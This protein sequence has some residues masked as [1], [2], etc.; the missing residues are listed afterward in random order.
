MAKIYISSTYSDLKEYRE[1]VYDILRKMRHDVIAMEDYNSSDERPLEKCLADVDNNCDLYVGIFAWR[2]GYIPTKDNPLNKSITELEYRQ[3]TDSKKQRRIFLLE[4]RAPW[5]PLLMDAVTGDSEQGKR[6]KEFR[7]ELGREHIAGFFKAPDE[8]ASLVAAAVNEWEKSQPTPTPVKPLVTAKFAPPP[9]PVNFIA[10]PEELDRLR[11]AVLSGNGSRQVALTAVVGMGGTGKSVLATALCHD[12]EVHAAFPDGVIWVT[13]GR[14]PGN[15]VS[16]LAAVEVALGDAPEHYTTPEVSRDRFRALVAS[17]TALL[18]LDDVWHSWCVEA[19]RAEA[20]HCR[21]IFTTRDRNIALSLSAQEIRLGV[22][23][24]DQAH[25]LLQEWAGRDDPLHPAIAERLGCLPVALKLAGA[26]L[27]EGMSGQEWLDTF[28]HVSQM[29][30]SRRATNKDENLQ[31]CFALSLEQL[32]PGDQQLYHTF[33]VFPEDLP[34]PQATVTRLSKQLQ[35]QLSDFDCQELLQ[36]FDRLALLEYNRTT[37]TLLLHDLLY[38][39]AREQLNDHVATTH[40]ALLTAYNSSGKAWAQIPNDGYLYTHLAYHLHAAQRTD[41]LQPLLFD[42]DWLHA[43]LAAT[44]VNAVLSDYDYVA[45]NGDAQLLQ[46]AIRLSAHVVATDHH[47]LRSQLQGRLRAHPAPALQ[48][49]CHRSSTIQQEVTIECL[50]ATLTAPGGPLLRTLSGHSGSV[51]AVGVLPD[52]QHLVSA[53]N[54][55]TLKVWDWRTGRILATFT[56]DHPLTTCVV[57]SDGKTVIVG[58]TGGGCIFY[59]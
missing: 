22:L 17:K 34:V 42:C 33:G 48:Q 46:D 1:A 15:L 19:F 47:Q 53:S 20:P 11:S 4:P 39:Y 57:T 51:R 5:S 36:E 3:A 14:E 29:R 25:A 27:R 56:A 30:L 37:R 40:T 50:S 31:T 43:K 2:Y 21:T 35:P 38:D 9:L 8:L 59:T 16:Q 44:D 6:I 32:P 58:D 45:N 55:R 52:G 49:L 13:I 26:R 10:R 23:T 7:E 28:R 41:E 54:D 12:R 24:D 18:V